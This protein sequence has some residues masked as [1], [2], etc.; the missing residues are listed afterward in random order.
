MDG[1]VTRGCCC[2]LLATQ[3]SERALGQQK[4]PVAAG[5]QAAKATI[6]VPPIPAAAAAASISIIVVVVVGLLR[7]QPLPDKSAIAA[8]PSIAAAKHGKYFSVL[9]GIRLRARNSVRTHPIR[10]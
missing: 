2:T 8:A 10:D 7:E 3:T 1:L 6:Y 5:R 9:V 4:Q